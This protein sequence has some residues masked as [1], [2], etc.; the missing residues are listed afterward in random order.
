MSS[1]VVVYDV[2]QLLK[3][4]TFIGGVDIDDGTDGSG[5]SGL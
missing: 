2:S 1:S 5:D 3:A 4:L